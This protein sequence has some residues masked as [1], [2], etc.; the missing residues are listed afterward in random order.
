M[1][2]NLKFIIYFTSNKTLSMK[3]NVKFMLALSLLLV[4]ISCTTED[5]TIA[6]NNEVR[7]QYLKPTYDG[8][9]TNFV[10][11]VQ[12][13]ESSINYIF[14][15]AITSENKK[16]TSDKILLHKGESKEITIQKS[17]LHLT[18]GY[19]KSYQVRVIPFYFPE[20]PKF[21]PFQPLPRPDLRY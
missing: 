7:I 14:V 15:E 1:R 18:E 9:S 19:I 12:S 16:L 10:F 2:I 5:S 13:I 11:N 4:T 6:K 21:P 20:N 17:G 8:T 3:L